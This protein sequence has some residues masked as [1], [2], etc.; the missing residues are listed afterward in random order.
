MGIL[1]IE[2]RAENWKTARYFAPFIASDSARALLAERLG[3]PV[4]TPAGDIRIELFWYG[5]RDHIEQGKLKVKDLTDDFAQSYLKCFRNLRDEIKEFNG[6][7][8]LKDWNYYVSDKI[9][10]QKPIKTINA[11]EELS[12]N[13][14][15]TETDIVLQTKSHLF[16]GEAKHE[17]PLDAKSKYVLVHQLIRQYV[18]AR[19]LVDLIP[20]NKQIVPFVVGDSDQLESIR[21]TGQVKFMVKKGWLKK[22]NVLSWDEIEKLYP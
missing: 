14:I 21:N 5:M 12:S 7:E 1:G 20:S 3:K 8:A 22:E 17:S 4:G 6:F 10:V 19:I 13:L 18:M 11:A 16:I 2:N 15:H 9:L